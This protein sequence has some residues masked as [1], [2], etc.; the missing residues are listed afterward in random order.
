MLCF[1]LL[2]SVDDGGTLGAGE[3]GISGVPGAGS[4]VKGGGRFASGMLEGTGEG[5]SGTGLR[6]DEGSCKQINVPLRA[7]SPIAPGSHKCLR[8]PWKTSKSPSYQKRI[9]ICLLVVHFCLF[10]CLIVRMVIY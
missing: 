10:I 3:G 1:G 8:S 5:C 2:V 7:R 9:I 6:G 4:M